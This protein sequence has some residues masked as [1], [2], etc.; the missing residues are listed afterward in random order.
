MNELKLLWRARSEKRINTFPNLS[1]ILLAFKMQQKI[2]LEPQSFGHRHNRVEARHF[3]PT[4]DVAPKI[5]GDVASFS[6]FLKAQSCCFPELSDALRKQGS[7]FRTRHEH[8]DSGRE[9]YLK[10]SIEVTECK[11]SSR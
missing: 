2:G 7:M 8:N 4:L 5:A 9:G 10:Q 6:S 11:N 3:F 1:R